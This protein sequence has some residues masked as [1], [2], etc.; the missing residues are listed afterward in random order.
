MVENLSTFYCLHYIIYYPKHWFGHEIFTRAYFVINHLC[1]K[2]VTLPNLQ[3]FPT[4]LSFFVNIFIIQND[5]LSNVGYNSL[6]YLS[7][8]IV[9]VKI[10]L[11]SN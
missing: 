6:P 8:G 5:Q 9:G 1:S 4:C 2:S 3:I 10:I 7:Y 11:M